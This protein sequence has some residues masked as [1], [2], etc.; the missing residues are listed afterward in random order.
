MVNPPLP[1]VVE[2]WVEHIGLFRSPYASCLNY[3]IDHDSNRTR[4]HPPLLSI[5]THLPAVVEQW[6]H[7]ELSDCWLTPSLTMTAI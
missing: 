7:V 1:A 2:Q 3:P 4:D 5:L 6:V